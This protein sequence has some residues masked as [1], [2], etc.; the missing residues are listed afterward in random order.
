MH[1]FNPG[2]LGAEAGGSPYIWDQPGLHSTG[3]LGLYRETQSKKDKKIL[4]KNERVYPIEVGCK[5]KGPETS[6]EQE[7]QRVGVSWYGWDH[8]ELCT[9]QAD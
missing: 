6:E 8:R 9:C 1:T 7:H 5:S 3:Q 2:T 4:K